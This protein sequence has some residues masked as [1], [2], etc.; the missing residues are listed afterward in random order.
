[1]ACLVIRVALPD[2]LARST[3][4]CGCRSSPPRLW[5]DARDR[6]P[7]T[8]FASVLLNASTRRELASTLDERLQCL[9]G[10]ASR[11]VLERHV[12]QGVTTYR[13]RTGKRCEKKDQ[14]SISHC[15]A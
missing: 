3:A 11:C 2:R 13:E 6:L 12:S 14:T 1:M 15:L 7:K 10:H 5:P 8:E 9:P 4:S